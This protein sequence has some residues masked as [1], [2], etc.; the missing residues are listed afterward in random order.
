MESKRPQASAASLHER[1]R[2]RTGAGGQV[3][4]QLALKAAGLGG[5]CCAAVALEG[6]GVRLLTGD[7][8]LPGEDLRCLAHEQPTAGVRQP[9][10]ESYPRHEVPRPKARNEG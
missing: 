4:E 3:G 6:E 9:F 2:A 1:A 5:G 7:S 10:K 8:E